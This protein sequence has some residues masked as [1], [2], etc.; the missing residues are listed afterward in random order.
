MASRGDGKKKGDEETVQEE[1]SPVA[2][3]YLKVRHSTNALTRQSNEQPFSFFFFIF[4]LLFLLIFF[5][6]SRLCMQCTCTFPLVYSS[7]THVLFRS[8]LA[9]VYLIIY[10][11][12]RSRFHSFFSSIARVYAWSRS[13]L[14]IMSDNGILHLYPL[15]LTLGVN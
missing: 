10:T 13:H 9:R 12:A 2:P 6:S 8:S 1:L 4:F 5:A 7:F 15:V 11:F 3:F 14:V